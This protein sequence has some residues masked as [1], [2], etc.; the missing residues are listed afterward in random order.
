MSRLYI[1]LGIVG[2][3]SVF[4]T[5]ILVGLFVF[6]NS[7]FEVLLRSLVLGISFFVGWIAA[8]KLDMIKRSRS[9]QQIK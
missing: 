7:F 1:Q 9:K 6:E 3:V 8:S 5:S 2:G 4:V